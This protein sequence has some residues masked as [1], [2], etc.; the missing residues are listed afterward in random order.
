MEVNQLS[1]DDFHL[2][3][4]SDSLNHVTASSPIPM[5]QMAL[6]LIPITNVAPPQ[7]MSTE[8]MNLQFQKKLEQLE[9]QVRGSKVKD[10]SR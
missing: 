7:P 5:P 8:Q 6:G 9:Q 10:K 1:S 4:F 2:G 3:F